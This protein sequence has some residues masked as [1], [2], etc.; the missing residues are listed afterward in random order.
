MLKARKLLVV[1]TALLTFSAT[2]GLTLVLPK[3]YTATA[4]LYIDYRASDPIAGRQFH[5]MLDESYMQTQFDILKSEEVAR[6]VIDAT[7]M[8]D[9]PKIKDLIRRKGETEVRNN[10]VVS[11]GRAFEVAV[12][13]GS[14]VVELKYSSNDPTHARDALNAAIKGY[15]EI[16]T[17]INS[18]PA[19]SRQ[20]QYNTQLVSLRQDMDRIQNELTQY[21]QE[22]GILDSDE[23]T[24]TGFRQLNELSTRHLETQ[25]Q[26]TEA[27]ARKR[28]I[29]AMLNA[30]IPAFD[31]PDIAQQKGIQE[32]K[33][34]LVEINGKLAEASNVLG[35]NHPR[36]RALVTE[37]DSVQQLLDKEAQNMLAALSLED[38]KY[39]QH[40]SKLEGEMSRLRSQLLQMKKHRDVMGSY[41]RQLESVQRIYNSAVQKYDE[42]LM[43]SNVS[44]PTL[45]VLRWAATPHTHAKP[46]MFNNL[47][48]SIPSGVILGLLAAFL[49]ELANRRLRCVE[50]LQRAFPFPVLGRSS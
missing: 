44:S 5:P 36:H 28:A 26:Y 46:L 9:E 8:L 41:Q 7:R 12:R 6:H 4:E 15:I 27:N 3:T 18:A 37:R 10:L 45:A 39:S 34:R 20:E 30:G 29:Q 38:Q 47:L 19:R 48:F 24:D 21:Q 16:T 42:I 35:A 14:R 2:L 32:L 22:A 13:R 40:A 49:I 50:D 31:V 33:L 23:R 11:V 25:A 17:N 43:A 1:M